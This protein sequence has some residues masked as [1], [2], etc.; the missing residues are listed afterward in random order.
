[1]HKELR[2]ILEAPCD[3]M[4]ALTDVD[5]HS[6]RIDLLEH[7][8]LAECAIDRTDL[9]DTAFVEKV[10]KSQLSK[11]NL[12]RSYQVF[13]GIFYELLGTQIRSHNT[14]L[15]GR[16]TMILGIDSTFIRTSMMQAGKYRRS[17]TEDGIK[18]QIP[19]LLFPLTLPIDVL[20][21][22]ANNNDS[23]SS[24]RLLQT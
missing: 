24:I 20:V 11:L 22:P 7:V 16:Y 18:V 10:S 3:R 19:A 5:I 6:K 14:H 4:S 23:P 9:T 15:Y 17:K 21:T 13:T 8:L 12:T 2:R 1:M